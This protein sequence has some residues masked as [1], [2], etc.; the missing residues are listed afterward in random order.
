MTRYSQRQT[1]RQARAIRPQNNDENKVAKA[2]LATGKSI[3]TKPVFGV[4]GSN[5]TG[6]E[7][8][9]EKAGTSSST[10]DIHGKRK[11]DALGEVTNGKPTSTKPVLTE[12][13]VLVNR[14]AAGSATT[15]SK[16]LIKKTIR[17]TH[18]RKGSTASD[19][20]GAST[21]AETSIPDRGQVSN[22]S[23][24]T[25]IRLTR[26]TIQKPYV[27]VK[28]EPFDEEP[29]NK[30]RKTSPEAPS[31]SAQI[32]GLSESDEICA[33]EAIKEEEEALYKLEEEETV[34]PVKEGVD[35]EGWYDI[36]AEDPHDM[37][38]V[39]E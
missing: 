1:R 23:V 17:S 14:D 13:K 3:K 10:T 28:E 24:T 30:R 16:T 11:R 2:T 32:V 35:I 26:R 25:H 36:D 9:F 22:A 15:S 6:K 19:A 33:L 37:T 27:D 5:A 12:K 38:M 8:V 29:V 20:D 39:A 34:V 18:I 21:A 4:G 31:D 7:R